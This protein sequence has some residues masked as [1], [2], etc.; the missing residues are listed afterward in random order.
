MDVISVA[1]DVTE[2]ALALTFDDGPSQWTPAVLDLLREHDATA[3]FFV[4]GRWVDTR[5][6]TSPLGPKRALGSPALHPGCR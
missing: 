2:K 6:D 3:T 4:V 5:G 1:S